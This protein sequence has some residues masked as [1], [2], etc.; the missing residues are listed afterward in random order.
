MQRF[1]NLLSILFLCLIPIFSSVAQ[2]TNDD[3]VNAQNIC[4]NTSFSGTT[5]AAGTEI[6]TGCAD[7]ATAA[8]NF[9]FAI[10]RTIWFSFLT[11]STGGNADVV[12]SNI[13]CFIGAGYDT[14]L[15]AVVIQAGT[16]CDESTYT[17]VS[18]CEVGTST[19]FT[20][21]ATGLLPNTTYFIQINGDLS[22]A[23]ITNSAE[24]DFNIEVSGAAVDPT[25]ITSTTPSDCGV[26]DGAFTVNSVDGGQSAYTFSLDGGNFQAATNFTSLSAG[27]H[28]LIVQDANGCLFFSDD[29]VIQNNGPQNSTANITPATCNGND[30]T[31]QIVNTTGGNPAYSYLLV[32]G[33]SQG[34]NSFINL[35]AGSYTIII[36]DQLSCSDTVV[37]EITNTSGI[38][39]VSTTIVPSDCGQ[40]TGEIAVIVG[41]GTAPFQYSLNGGV[42]QS[43]AIFSNLAAGSYEILVTDAGGCT[44]LISSAIVNENP[45]DQTPVVTVSQSPNPA[46]TGDAI[47]FTSS[48]TNGGAST[49]YEFFV[50]GASVQN[51]GNAVFTSSS[52]SSGDIITCMV[53]SN[54]ACVAIN[55]DESAQT[56]LTILTPFTPN[57][58][59]TSSDS[60][61]CQGEQV[62]ITATTDCST[63]GS[64]DWVVDGVTIATTT[65]N[66]NTF[67][68]T[69][70]A[71]IS[72]IANC[73][74]AC[75]LPSTSNS[76]NI[77]VTEIIA[78]AGDD[79]MI[80]PGEST[81]LNGS[82]TTGGTFSWT[83]S[84]SLSNPNVSD[85]T[86][87]PNSTTTYLLTVTAN[88][89]TATDEVTIVV[90]QLVVAPNTFT[91]NGDGTN[92]TWQILRIEDYPN[93]EVNIYDRWGQKI[94][95]TMGYS[96]ANPWDGTNGGL[97]LPASTYF[98]VIDLKIGSDADIYHGS[99]TI[100]Y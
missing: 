23:G 33:G 3:C 64:F 14:D 42:S 20:L 35:P 67:S 34:S 83:P 65:S 95:K 100:V 30:G 44:F 78:D 92:D 32:G 5:F 70:D 53:T 85:P 55:T 37:A 1:S 26:N 59:I 80:A 24:C 66:S 41:N 69:N 29:V 40:N 76:I 84:S 31:I 51:S 17:A 57:T 74:D 47:S 18:N 96:N 73:D 89:C 60:D 48:V 15:Q 43:S 39:N 16:P 61:I 93:C 63:N 8:G 58:T 71:Q 90:S 4:P 87:S 99:V 82:G 12:I 27:T 25:I 6:C 79:Q 9:C 94:Y 62:T 2:T 68:L 91:P 49:N 50:N 28:S 86:S 7:G 97:K 88:G 13:S 56:N 75:A 46:C 81:I 54:D 22:G 21:N 36:S 19:D 98:F 72:V 10:N 11:N 52:L 45:P 38:S 77:A